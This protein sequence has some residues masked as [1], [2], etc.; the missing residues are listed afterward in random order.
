MAVQVNGKRHGFESVTTT[1][2]YPATD[3]DPK[4]IIE[5][6]VDR[7]TQFSDIRL[8]LST[9]QVNETNDLDPITL[10]VKDGSGTYVD[11]DFW[12]WD[13]DQDAAGLLVDGFTVEDDWK[14][15]SVASGAGL[16]SQR[17]IRIDYN[18]KVVG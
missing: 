17:T 1:Y 10:Y 4:T 7:P 16:G 11:V 8:N 18:K 2:D 15:T 12:S 13:N 14:L 6:T 3:T 9:I 5:V